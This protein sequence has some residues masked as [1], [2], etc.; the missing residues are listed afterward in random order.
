MVKK[1]VIANYAIGGAMALTFYAE[2]TLTY[3]LDVFV[4]LFKPQTSTKIIDLRP[5]YAYCEV[6]HY[7]VKQEHVFIEGVAVQFIPAYNRLVE[8]AVKN[9][10]SIKYGK[11]FAQVITL[12]YLIVIMLQTARPKDHARLVQVL[13]DVAIDNKKLQTILTINGL[14]HAWQ[15]FQKKFT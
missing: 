8:D 12:E 13:S 5:I 14:T 6:R 7:A 4:F 2:P 9:A 3:D 15:N 11:T 1:K 10:K